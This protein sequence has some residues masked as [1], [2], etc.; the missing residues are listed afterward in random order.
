MVLEKASSPA[1]VDSKSIF[2]IPRGG[3]LVVGSALGDWPVA[4]FDE[5]Q[6]GDLTA[7]PDVSNVLDVID[8]IRDVEVDDLMERIGELVD[9]VADTTPGE[10]DMVDIRENSSEIDQGP[11]RPDTGRGYC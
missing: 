4:Q 2:P 1:T 6:T 7:R 3:Y 10:L 9:E 11:T 8:R 5:P